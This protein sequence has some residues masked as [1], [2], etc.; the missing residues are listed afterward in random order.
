MNAIKTVL[1]IALGFLAQAALA[2]DGAEIY[3]TRCAACHETPQTDLARPPPAR[4]V[5]QQLPAN[6]VYNALSQGVMRMQA[7]GLSNAQM[8]LVSE[9]LTGKPVEQLALEM[10]TN[11]CPSN[12]PLRDPALSP[13][14]NGWGGDEHN[15]RAAL[16]AGIDA[17]NV[18]KLRLKWVFGLPGEDQ[19]RAQP[20]IADGRLFVGN[21]A[22]A[23]YSLDAKTGCTYWTYLPRNGIRSAISIGP[24]T[25]AD[26]SSGF[27]AYF[28]DLRAN[29]YAVN[30][31]TGAELWT[32][33]VETH[34]GVRGTGSVTF[35]DGF[36]YVPAAGVVEETSSSGADYGC[37]TFRGSITKVNA[38]TGEVVW[39]TY[40]MSE[41]RP[42]GVNAEGVQQYGPSGAG[43]WSAPTIDAAR[44][45]L[46][47][48]TGNAYGEPAPETSDAV[49]ALD[50]ASG[51]ITWV[52]QLTPG[53]AFISGCN[54]G[55]GVNCPE[56]LGPDFDFSASPIL[57]TTASGKELLVIPQKSGV[58]YALDP[59][60]A[61]SVVW[62]YRINAG[63]ASGGFW[64]MAVA[65][66][67]TYVGASGYSLPDSGGIHAIDVET[68]ERA[69]YSPPQDLL[70]Q[71]GFGCRA[72]QS[73][74]VTAIPG[75]V[76]SGAAD[77]GLRVYSAED[78]DVLWTFDSNPEFETIN[79]VPAAG[80]SFDGPG[81]VI[82]DGMVYVLSGNC[83]IVGR[84]GN[85]LF[86]FELAPEE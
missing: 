21:K 62:E 34:P 33:R 8:Q 32:A 50:L 43:I 51:T 55:P 15:A 9:Y 13:G 72:T 70:C 79:G 85:A 46:Y 10:T 29:V 45:L 82:V 41:A 44:G 47:T 78:G 16:T 52:N 22:G 86:A 80:G 35:H 24:V 28:V 42:R 30:A 77:G 20:A 67:K 49:L 14:W 65:D 2:Q 84:P 66:G 1:C 73:A 69:W 19:P 17:A 56:E 5:L 26:G 38:N 31:Q 3:T 59:D 11:L 76:F 75:A 4:T 60:D 27:A 71:A 12:P 25:L 48:A 39:K 40:M 74:A 63:S 23:L 81:P 57:T 18:S 58:A 54:N 37:C 6:T 36:L 83:C 68:G 61:G 53:D 7:T 64:G